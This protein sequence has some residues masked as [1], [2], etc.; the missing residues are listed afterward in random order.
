MDL[1]NYTGAFNGSNL[2]VSGNGRRSRIGNTVVLDLFN[3][4]INNTS[5][6]FLQS[7]R[8]GDVLNSLYTQ[9]QQLS[10][11]EK[12]EIME[13]SESISLNNYF[14]DLAQSVLNT[15]NISTLNENA[16]NINRYA[17][18]NRSRNRYTNSELSLAEEHFENL[19]DSL[20]L[21]IPTNEFNFYMSTQLK[22]AILDLYYETQAYE[23]PSLD[24]IVDRMFNS[25]CS[26]V[27][28]YPQHIVKKVIKQCI[29]Y[30]GKVPSC[31]LYP[32]YVEYYIL[33]GR[34]P[35]DNELEEY[36][37]R[38]IDFTRN[39][40]EFHQKD[41]TFVPA[42]NI[43][44]LPREKYKCKGDD[45]DVCC[46]CQE[47]FKEDQEVI[48]LLPCKHTFHDKDEECLE[49]GSILTWLEKHNF[50]PLCKSHISPN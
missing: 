34:I 6:S 21:D 33:H 31:E 13:D 32:Q 27:Y 28:S 23:F 10:E 38:L 39:P 48:T 22:C 49:G 45:E 35:N 26:C 43:D 47:E 15:F 12:R 30:E 50:C 46:I 11:E 4:L 24:E 7:A 25:R 41:K 8:R 20:D 19:R 16:I 1:R 2:N 37:R 29:L 44:K 14:P 18:S 42:L 9:V 3:T 36:I 5:N 40:E 17:M